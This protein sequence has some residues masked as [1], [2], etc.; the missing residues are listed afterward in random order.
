VFATHVN[1]QIRLHPTAVWTERTRPDLNRCA[2]GRS[3]LRVGLKYVLLETASLDEAFT[4]PVDLADMVQLS[5]MLLHVIKHRILTLLCNTAVRTDKLAR[6]IPSVD[7][8]FLEHPGVPP[9]IAYPVQLLAIPPPPPPPPPS[10]PPPP[11]S[12]NRGPLYK[13]SSDHQITVGS[14]AQVFHGTAKHTAGG[15]TKKDLVKNKH[16]RIVSRK[17]MEAGKKALK[18]LTRKGYKAKKGEFHLFNKYRRTTKRQQ[19]GWF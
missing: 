16:G 4:A 14:K 13:M 6:G 7:S 18:Y 19:G 9:P 3:Y 10:P 8:A 2:L 11:Q 5:G 1:Q 12:K 17:K 15:L